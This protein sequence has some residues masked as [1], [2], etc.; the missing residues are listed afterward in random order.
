[1]SA[2]LLPLHSRKKEYFLIDP[3]EA[4][5][6][7]FQAQR[8]ESRALSTAF[9]AIVQDGSKVGKVGE[10]TLAIRK[11]SIL[12]KKE[13][14]NCNVIRYQSISVANNGCLVGFFG[15]EVFLYALRSQ[16][17]SPI[18]MKLQSKDLC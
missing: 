6:T 7:G 14:C 5:R 11:P 12:L 4:I 13:A 17:R 3:K 8:R 16:V 10:Q 15:R 1:M 2:F 9:Q 18:L